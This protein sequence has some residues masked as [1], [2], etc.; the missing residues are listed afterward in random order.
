MVDTVKPV[1]EISRFANSIRRWEAFWALKDIGRPLWMLP[2]TPVL[3][4]LLVRPVPLI[5]LLLKKEV[6]LEG[7]IALLDWRKKIGIRDDFIPHLRPQVGVTMFPS[8]FGC[9]VQ[10]FEHTMPWAHPLIKETDPPEKVFD[11]PKPSVRAGQL[12]QMLEFTEYFVKKTMGRLP[13]AVSDVQGPLDTAY[14]VWEPSAFMLAMYDRPK[15]VHHLMRLAT[16]LAIDYVKEQRRLSPRFIPCHYPPLWLPDGK[17]IAVSDDGMAVISAELYREFCLPYMNE[18]SD[19]FG[20][21]FL[22]SCGGF[23]HQ[24][25]NIE[26]ID[27][28]RGINFGVTETPFEAVWERFN[29][30]TA[31]VPHLGLN[32][33]PQFETSRHFLEHVLA[34]KTHNRGLCIIVTPTERDM[35]A[36]GGV[37][38][39]GRFMEDVRETIL[40]HG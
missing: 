12:G 9:E 16:D 37:P 34:K 35:E 14:M 15:A 19:A 2:T 13:I 23:A 17:G 8:A 31:I 24:F 25:A 1:A 29:G 18:I 32:N 3:T 20:G 6:Q 38:G 26:R 27:N 30:K 22:H 21:L 36:I 40:D 5:D 39:L 11:L 33:P 7:Q 4:S 10:F 28:L